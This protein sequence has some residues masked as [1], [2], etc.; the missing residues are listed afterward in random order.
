MRNSQ[1]KERRVF[2]G[3]L[4]LTPC[5]SERKWRNVSK[6]DVE[7]Y[8]QSV[9]YLIPL[10]FYSPLVLKRKRIFQELCKQGMSWDKKIPDNLHASWTKWQSNLHLLTDLKIPRCYKPL[11]FCKIQTMELHNFSDASSFGYGQCSYSR[12]M[13]D[14]N[15]IHCCVGWQRHKWPHLNH[16]DPSTGS[17]LV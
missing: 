3:V 8:L 10:V 5:N 17:L 1:S 13:D 16:N 14:Q 11:E 15:R 12:L 7:F 6:L 4:N 9:R 2:N